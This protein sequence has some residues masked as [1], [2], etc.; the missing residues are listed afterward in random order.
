MCFL[1]AKDIKLFLLFFVS[2]LIG[3]LLILRNFSLAEEQI[4][5]VGIITQ[6]IDNYVKVGGQR[7][8]LQIFYCHL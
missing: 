4:S 1:F 6:K 5:T 2:I 7:P 3:A 8:P